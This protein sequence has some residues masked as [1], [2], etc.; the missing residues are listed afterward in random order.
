MAKG[1][2]ETAFASQVEDLLDLYRWHWMHPRP[3]RTLHGWRTAI[4]GKVGYFDYTAVRPPR[5]LFIELKDEVTKPTPEQEEWAELVRACQTT[6]LT[7]PLKVKGG[8]AY[9]RLSEVSTTQTPEVFLWRPNQIEEI[10]E[11]LR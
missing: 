9:M 6:L 1:I 10:V 8:N 2:S 11:I 7:K 3:A 4:A 5:L